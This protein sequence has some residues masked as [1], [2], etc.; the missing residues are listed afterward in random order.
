MYLQKVFSRKNSVQKLVFGWHLEVNDE[1]SRNRIQDPDL[2]P[3]QNVMDP[4]H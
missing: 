1:N 4:Q 2:D 3:P